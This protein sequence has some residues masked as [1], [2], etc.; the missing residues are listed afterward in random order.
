MINIPDNDEIHLRFSRCRLAVVYRNEWQGELFVECEQDW[1]SVRGRKAPIVGFPNS[2]SIFVMQNKQPIVWKVVDGA[3]EDIRQLFK[4]ALR[5][6]ADTA[7]EVVSLEGTL[8]VLEVLERKL[9][10]GV[11]DDVDLGEEGEKVAEDFV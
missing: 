6:M 1:R 9:N 7:G 8:A 5:L 4:A 10:R 11:E 2:N 3:R